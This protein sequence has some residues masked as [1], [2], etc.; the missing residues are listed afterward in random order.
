MLITSYELWNNGPEK[1]FGVNLEWAEQYPNTHRAV[2]MALLRAARW[3]DAHE[4]RPQVAEILSRP[5]YVNAP[6]ELIGMSN[7]QMQDTEALTERERD[8][9]QVIDDQAPDPLQLLG[10]VHL[11]GVA[12]RPG[13]DRPASRRT[14]RSGSGTVNQ[15]A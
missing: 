11:D 1:V 9:L 13:I 14:V 7:Q 15:S 6:K 3:L 5:A 2:L 8:V 4:N 12:G 10:R